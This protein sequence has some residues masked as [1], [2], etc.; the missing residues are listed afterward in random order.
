[1]GVRSTEPA[2]RELAVG[3]ELVADVP[4]RVVLAIA[5]SGQRSTRSGGQI[6]VLETGQDEQRMQPTDLGE[7]DWDV[8][9]SG[10]QGGQ[11]PIGLGVAVVDADGAKVDERR[12]NL[13]GC[14]YGQGA[15]SFTVEMSWATVKR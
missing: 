7:K 2:G 4:K 12:R 11:G 5:F 3:R 9:R 10:P 13:R 15:S 14:V 8:G 1:L 6:G